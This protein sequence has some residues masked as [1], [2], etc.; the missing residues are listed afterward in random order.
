MFEKLDTPRELFT[1]KLG[2]A[3]EM[4]QTVLKML[5]NLQEEA[6]DGQLTELFRHH[7]G[8]TRQQIR[9]L[10]LAFEAV[11]EKP[12][13]KPC[14]AIEGIDKE[15]KANVKKASDQ[16]VDAVILSG[17][18]ETEHHEIAVY[19]GLITQAEA[20][21]EPSVVTL[22]RQNLE[23]EEHTLDEVRRAARAVAQRTR[24]VAA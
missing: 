23:Q 11:G 17:A 12:D 7:A 10:E 5:G 8:E 13:D 6:Q 21:D 3:L 15:G 16:L 20:L 4:E 1:Y 24:H 19:E 2:A 14:P 9:N 18:A 22:L